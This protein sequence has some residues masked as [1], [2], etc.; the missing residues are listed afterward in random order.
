MEVRC[1]ECDRKLAGFLEG[2]LV[3]KCPRC[4]EI[5]TIDKRIHVPVG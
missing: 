3:I 1:P 5:V 4:K 2:L